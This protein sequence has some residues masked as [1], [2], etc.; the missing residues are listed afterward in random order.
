M[1]P[2]RLLKA[3]NL[4]YP[5]TNRAGDAAKIIAQHFAPSVCLWG[6]SETGKTS[7]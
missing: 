2:E 3:T 1:Q 5:R 4:A 6:P 7:T